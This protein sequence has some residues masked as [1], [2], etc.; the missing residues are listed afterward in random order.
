VV[1]GE[2][3]QAEAVNTAILASLPGMTAI[4]DGEGRVLRANAAWNRYAEEYPDAFDSLGVNGNLLEGCSRRAAAGDHTAFEVLQGLRGVLG[5][6]RTEFA[7]TYARWSRDGQERWYDMLAERLARREGGAVITILDSTGKKSAERAAASDRAELA[8]VIRVATMGE[9]TA[10]LAHELSQPLTAILS[11]AQAGQRLLA[12]RPPDVAEVRDILADITENDRRAGEVVHRIRGLLKKGELELRPVDAN[13]VVRDVLR[14]LSSDLQFRHCHAMLELDP[15]LPPVQADVV[16]LQQVVLNLVLNG[17]EAMDGVSTGE[18]RLTL[19]TARADGD[20]VEV[21]V[22]DAGHGIGPG[23]LEQ[24]FDPFFTTKP[25]GLGMGLSI[26]RSIVLA[27]GGT[28]RAVD[29]ADGG[30]TVGFVLPVSRE[31]TNA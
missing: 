11:N 8:R 2:R 19:A 25:N 26:A 7:V 29:N 15:E 27:F 20:H 16:Q 13:E 28:I 4:L 18:R 9:L 30:A 17:L 1:E 3:R 21:A 24:M 22:R 31:S 14:L 12:R 23:R 5:G 6:T 10:S